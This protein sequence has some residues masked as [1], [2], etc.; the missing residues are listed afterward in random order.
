VLWHPFANKLKEKSRQEVRIKEIMVEGILSITTGESPTVIRDKLSSYLSSKEIAQ[1]DIE[2][3]E[4]EEAN[5]AQ[6]IS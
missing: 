2:G 5:V 1:M 6:E 3:R 4:Q